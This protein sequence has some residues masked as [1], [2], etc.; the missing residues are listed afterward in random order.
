M[1]GALGELGAARRR[2]LG[3]GP[4]AREHDGHD[5]KAGSARADRSVISG[6]IR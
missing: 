2:I 6:D 4:A 5:E 3:G 1:D